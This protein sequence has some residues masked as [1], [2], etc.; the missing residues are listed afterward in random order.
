MSSHSCD[1]GSPVEWAGLWQPIVGVLP[2]LVGWT[3]LREFRRALPTLGRVSG[4]RFTRSVYERTCSLVESSFL[5]WFSF[6]TGLRLE[7]FVRY[8]GERCTLS[9][10][11]R[12]LTSNEPPQFAVGVSW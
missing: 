2:F 8:S 5:R 4:T 1:N 10:A 3:E 7:F 11:H 6:G 9:G 12:R